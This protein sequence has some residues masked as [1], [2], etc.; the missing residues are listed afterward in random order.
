MEEIHFRNWERGDIGGKF[1]V[2]APP[3]ARSMGRAKNTR[4]ASRDS[5]LPPQTALNSLNYTARKQ[6]RDRIYHD[7]VLLFKR[8]REKKGSPTPSVAKLETIHTSPKKL[9]YKS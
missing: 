3:S 1:R 2:P 5:S 4:S 7:N 8:L 9:R 6:E